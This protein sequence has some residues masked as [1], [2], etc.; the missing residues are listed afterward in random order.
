MTDNGIQLTFPRRYAAGPTATYMTHM[1]AM[2]CRENNIEHRL[3][4]V[5][6]PWING[7]VQR[8]NRTIKEATVKR[9]H[10]DSHQRLETHL[11]DLI[12]TYDFGRW[13]KT[14]KD[15]TPCEFIC[16]RRTTELDRI[17]VDPLHQMPGLNT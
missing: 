7:Q 1:F 14:L 6:H 5:K 10:Y 12:A 4:E 2:R 3:T 13:L 9:Q 8:M 16:K 17:T 11:Q 15:L